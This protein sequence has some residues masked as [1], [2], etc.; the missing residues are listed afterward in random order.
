MG[1][2]PIYYLSDASITN[3]AVS[4]SGLVAVGCGNGML[5]IYENGVMLHRAPACHKSSITGLVFSEDGKLM[6]SIAADGTKIWTLPN[7]CMTH[8]MKVASAEFNPLRFSHNGG[9]L[10]IPSPMHGILLFETESW[11][12]LLQLPAQ[13][14]MPK[15]IQF[16]DD[17]ITILVSGSEVKA[18]HVQDAKD[19]IEMHHQSTWAL[20][21]DDVVMGAC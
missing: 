10:A 13:K 19:V 21:G 15:S 9:I 3:I 2:G 20:F 8:S 14:T 16:S 11:K 18:W 4:P 17:D 12:C 7:F 5:K 6:A 1:C